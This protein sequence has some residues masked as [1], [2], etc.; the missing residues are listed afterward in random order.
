MRQPNTNTRGGSW[1]QSE[2]DAV[3]NKGQI[4]PGND[5][6]VRRKDA[7]AAWITYAQY[8]KTQD[9]GE[10]WEIDHIHPVA[11]GGTDTLNNLQPLQWQ[12]NRGKGDNWPDWSCSVS[13]KV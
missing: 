12:N 6:R 13:A 11:S 5:P 4:V 7:C 2:I 9:G 1:S 10:G 3:W 8:G